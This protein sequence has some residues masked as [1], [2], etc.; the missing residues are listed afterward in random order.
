MSDTETLIEIL[1]PLGSCLYHYTRLETVIEHI[2]P[3]G[4]MIMN[5]FSKMRDP[6]ESKALNP[7]GTAAPPQSATL[8]RSRRFA[9]IYGK[10]QSV[11]DQVKV[12][13]LTRDGP[14]DG[15]PETAIFTR[16]FA[17]P[18]LW[19]QY[20]DKH[21]G[22]CLCFDKEALTRALMTEL[23]KHGKPEHGAVMYRDGPIA[24]TAYTFSLA[25]IDSES[26]DDIIDHLIQAGMT[27]LF[28]TKTKDWETEAEYRFVVPTR[29]IEPLPAYVRGALRAVILGELASEHYKPSIVTLL[30]QPGVREL[31][32]RILRVRWGD[33]A[34][35]LRDPMALG[36]S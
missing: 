35:F 9:A 21:R 3:S 20:A 30:E 26:D 28:F 16:G 4:R 8:E 6:R 19:E 25:Q 5:P 29:G 36:Y 14:A 17:H 1:D 27:E 10:S 18:R 23:A 15:D 34:P 13:S 32:V 33:G 12:L 31:N 24:P 22:V 2:L 11:K 7:V